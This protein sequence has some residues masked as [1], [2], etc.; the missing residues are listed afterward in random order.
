MRKKRGESGRLQTCRQTC[1]VVVIL[2]IIAGW[3]M[4]RPAKRCDLEF[5][6]QITKFQTFYH[7][8][9]YI[10]GRKLVYRMKLSLVIL[11][12]ALFNIDFP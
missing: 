12:E 7:H 8:L 3:E 6:L 1:V 5:T 10:T 4:S 11:I 9:M 2:F